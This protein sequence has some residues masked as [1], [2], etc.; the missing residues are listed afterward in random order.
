MKKNY[1]QNLY[2]KQKYKLNS[3]SIALVVTFLVHNSIGQL[4][5]GRSRND[6]E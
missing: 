5:T 1:N 2:R 6:Q 4:Q 3:N